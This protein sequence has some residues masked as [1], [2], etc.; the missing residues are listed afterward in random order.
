MNRTATETIFAV[1]SGGA[2]AALTVVRI[3]GPQSGPTLDRLTGRPRPAP[4]ALALRALSDGGAGPLDRALVAWFPGPRSYSGEDM[5]ELHLHG[6]R[7]IL[8]AL[9]EA[10]A[11]GGLLRPAAPGEFTRRAFEN[12]KLDLTAA[13]GVADLV[14]AQTE[15]QRRQAMRQ[16]E[17]AL[18]GVYEDWRG[19]LIHAMSRFEAEIDFSDEDIPA[20]LAASV[21]GDLAAMRTEMTAHLNDGHRG[22]RLR[23]GYEIAIV[24]APNAGKSSLLNRLAG[25]PAAIVSHIA[26]TTRD[27]VEVQM[28]FGG[29]PVIL[30]DT[31]GLRAA[32]E[33]PIEAEGVARALARA[34][35]ADLTLV[36]FDGA[37][38]PEL[39]TTSLGL[40][41]PQSITVFN[42]SDLL[43]DRKIPAFGQARFVVSAQSGEG[44]EALILALT[45]SV[46]DRLDMTGTAPLTRLRH[47]H[48]VEACVDALNRVVARQ[49]PELAAE[50]IRH[51]AHALGRITGRVDV[52]DV[53]DVIFSDFCI[54]K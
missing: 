30:A 44:L 18:A 46:R 33:N 8:A 50:D 7:A 37:L 52:E 47:R 39:D 27:V 13:E 49:A 20:S 3:S 36:V 14:A 2:G 31:A 1:A 12:G 17:G 10:L 54:G 16:T 15:A 4:R 45:E 26:G 24:G 53:L 6:G 40:V 43:D 23:D 48:A 28:D 25:R 34:E 29:F 38:L 42:K 35:A 19:R 32:A 51:A 21:A 11:A 5:V 41:G 22:E 9:V